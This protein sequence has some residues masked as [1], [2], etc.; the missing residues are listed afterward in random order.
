MKIVTRRLELTEITWADLENIH[1]LQSIFEVDE[2][3]TLGIPKDIEEITPLLRV[4]R[5]IP[6]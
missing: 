5:G 3:N 1:K 4:E 6:C 2:F